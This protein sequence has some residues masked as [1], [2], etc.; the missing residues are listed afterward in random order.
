MLFS[1]RSSPDA[2]SIS[3]SFV[4]VKINTSANTKAYLGGREKDRNALQQI[5]GEKKH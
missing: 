1:E 3:C 2:F 4:K 5:G